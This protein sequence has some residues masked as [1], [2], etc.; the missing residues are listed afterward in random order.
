MLNYVLHG[1]IRC[2]EGECKMINVTARKV[3]NSISISIPKQYKVEA[4][5]EYVT[6]KSKNGGLIFTPKIKNPFLSDEA[7]QKA[8]DKEWQFLAQE[9]IGK[10]V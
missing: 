1:K 7:F 10:D 5:T 6:Y 9:E 8:E 3:G 4:G 2:E